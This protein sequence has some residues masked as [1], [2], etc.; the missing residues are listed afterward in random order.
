MKIYNEQIAL[1]SQKPREAFNITTQVKAAVEKSGLRDG[2]AVV[3]S[4]QSNTA[5]VVNDDRADVLDELRKWLGEV[6]P[7]REI[8]ARQGDLDNFESTRFPSSLLQHQITVPFTEGRL[9]LAA[10]QALFFIEIEGYRPRR[11]VV[12]ILGE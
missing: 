3:S 10:G 8:E 2:I 7:A 12:K 11:I 9:D 5:I 4:L 6:R 1:Q